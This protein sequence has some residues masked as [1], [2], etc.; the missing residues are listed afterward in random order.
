MT[1]TTPTQSETEPPE[2]DFGRGLAYLKSQLKTLPAKAGVY[3]MLDK[4]GDALY[5]GKARD[6]SKRVPSYT[7]ANNLNGRLMRMVAETAHLEIIVTA[8]E[9]EALLLESNLIKQLRPRYNILLRDDKSFAHILLTSDH[10]FGRLVKHRGPQSKKG[11]Y[12]GPF[13]SA[14]AVNRT[15]TSMTRA[16]MLRTC[17]DSDFATRSR[18]CLQYQIKR[19][20]APCAS[21]VTPEAYQDQLD[22]ARRFL[23]GKTDEVQKTYAAQMHEA[24]EALEFET[25]A[26]WRNR[27]RALT[28]IQAS[29][30]IHI[31]GIKDADVIAIAKEGG[32]VCVQVFFIR[33]GTN[34]GNKAYFPAHVADAGKSEI[35]SAFIG[36]F[37]DDKVPAPFILVSDLPDNAPLLAEALSSQ[38]GKAISLSRPSRGS[39][40]KM[41]DMAVRNADEALAR[42]LSEK[43]SQHRLLAAIGDE[44]DMDQ[45]PERVEIYDNS[46]IQGT[47]AVGAMVCAGPDGFI[48]SA[49]RKFNMRSTGKYAVSDGDDFTMMR[50]MIFRRFERALRE[51]PERTSQNWPDLLLIDGGRGQLNAVLEVMR[52]LD[53]DDIMVVGVSKGPDRNAGREQ[54]HIDGKEA[55]TLP[56]DSPAMHFLQRLRDESHR[57]A[58]GA[59]RLRRTKSSLKSPLDDIEGVGPKRKKALLAHFGSAR[60]VSRAAIAD[61]KAVDGISEAT[62]SDIYHYF[63]SQGGKG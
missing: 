5:V 63:H 29:Q 58:I 9:V 21:L 16:F 14:G 19:C 36:Q 43:A 59:H 41:M 33:N 53:L 56:Q 28:A 46:H 39:R 30:D 22:Q 48:K 4:Q 24:A 57:F 40:R 23:S 8:T 2:A 3:R 38:A 62:A 50:Q 11:D 61:L 12:F 49:Y 47:N 31:D 54:F 35:L 37:Y 26:L 15:I 17:S 34:Y 25:A 1:N 52:E 10:E 20:T 51:D 32:Q 18:P 42:K 7:R 45:P 44:F 55:F 27:I 6:L 13:A 60:S